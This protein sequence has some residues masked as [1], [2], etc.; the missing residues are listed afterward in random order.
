[1]LSQL[2][3]DEANDANYSTMLKVGLTKAEENTS[4]GPNM[5]KVQ[6]HLMV[7]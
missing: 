4:K 3:F 1:M 6:V 5:V 2:Y 7:L